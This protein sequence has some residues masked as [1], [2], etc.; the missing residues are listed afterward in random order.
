M[1]FYLIIKKT[2]RD[3]K[4]ENDLLQ[5][6]NGYGFFIPDWPPIRG[7]GSGVGSGGLPVDSSTGNGGSFV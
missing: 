4:L 5:G 2:P 1:I 6:I 3:S 7:L